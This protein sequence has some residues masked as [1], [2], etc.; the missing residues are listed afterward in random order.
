MS[1][2][3]KRSKKIIEENRKDV[4]YLRRKLALDLI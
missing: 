4:E 1:E 2:E 3:E